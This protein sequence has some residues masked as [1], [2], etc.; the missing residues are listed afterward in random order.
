MWCHGGRAATQSEK[1]TG[2]ANVTHFVLDPL[3]GCAAYMSFVY[4]LCGVTKLN[5]KCIETGQKSGL[6]EWPW[7]HKSSCLHL[8]MQRKIFLLLSVPVFIIVTVRE[9]L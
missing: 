6:F 2:N 1:A 4:D 7:L 8:Q 3:M 5:G 9:N